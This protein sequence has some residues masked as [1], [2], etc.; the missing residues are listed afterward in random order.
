VQSRTTENRYA[1]ADRFG[2]S[3]AGIGSRFLALVI[4]IL[5][6]AVLFFVVILVFAVSMPLG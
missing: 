6:Q 3:L 2:T 5:L 4:D 1:R